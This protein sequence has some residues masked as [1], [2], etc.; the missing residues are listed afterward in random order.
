MNVFNN[1]NNTN[2][3][4][5]I[6]VIDINVRSSVMDDDS[7]IGWFIFGGFVGL[8]IIG[9][10]AI[11]VAKICNLRQWYKYDDHSWL[12][13]NDN[14][15]NCDKL[16]TTN[17]NRYKR[18][19]DVSHD[20]NTT[21]NINDVTHNA[22]LKTSQ[23]SNPNNHNS[24]MRLACDPWLY[25][26]IDGV[27]SGYYEQYGNKSKFWRIGIKFNFETNEV[28]CKS[29]LYRDYN[30]TMKDS[31]GDYKMHGHF[32]T[33]NKRMI[34]DKQYIADTGNSKE[35]L[36]HQVRIRLRWNE[37]RYSFVGQY[38]VKTKKYQGSD[39]WCLYITSRQ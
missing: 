25:P 37:K 18:I 3:S 28:T 33:E 32:N 11:Y 26:F 21:D 35:N 5:Y 13:L 9:Y 2:I 34:L 19:I 6:T 10:I 8:V 12:K 20:L 27:Y 4:D 39:E 29:S 36:G 1:E 30:D 16:K 22:P 15:N 17:G 24:N 38:Y 23:I 31:I 14:N 7:I